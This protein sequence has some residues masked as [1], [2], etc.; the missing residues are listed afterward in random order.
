MTHAEFEQ[1][2][3]ATCNGMVWLLSAPIGWTIGFI[4]GALTALFLLTIRGMRFCYFEG[5]NLLK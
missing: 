1:H 3:I 2:T 5:L 4:L